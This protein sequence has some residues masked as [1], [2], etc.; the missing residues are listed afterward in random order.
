MDYLTF[1][2]VLIFSLNIITIIFRAYLDDC[3]LVREQQRRKA[4]TRSPLSKRI[5]ANLKSLHRRVDTLSGKVNLAV[6]SGSDDDN[7]DGV[8]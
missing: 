4:C 1:L 2:I 5:N 7:A 6:S 8:E 3:V